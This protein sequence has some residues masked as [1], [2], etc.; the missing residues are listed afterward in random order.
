MLGELVTH[1]ALVPELLLIGHD[2]EITAA[3]WKQF[4]ARTGEGAL[5]RGTQT[6]RLWLVVSHHAVFDRDVHVRS[7]SSSSKPVYG[8]PCV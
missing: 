6:G 5:D 3:T 7:V 8:G 2:D 4:D 1:A